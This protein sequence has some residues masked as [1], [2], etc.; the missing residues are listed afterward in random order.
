[1]DI[2]QLVM[3]GQAKQAL[4]PRYSNEEQAE[5]RFDVKDSQDNVFNIEIT[6]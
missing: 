2:T 4:P 3:S 6:K 1:M 5:L